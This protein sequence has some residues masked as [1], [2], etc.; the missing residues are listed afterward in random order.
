MEIGQICH[1]CATAKGWRPVTM[2]D[3]NTGEQIPRPVGMWEGK[4]DVCGE[5]KSLCAPRD[6]IDP[7]RPVFTSVLDI[8]KNS[9]Y[10]SDSKSPPGGE[11][12]EGSSMERLMRYEFSLRVSV[13]LA[14]DMDDPTP[15]DSA[16][17]REIL[18]ENA[19]DVIGM[20]SPEE[21]AADITEIRLIEDSSKPAATFVSV[22][23]DLGEVA[24]A[25]RYDPSRKFA[26]DIEMSDADPGGL[27]TDEFVRLE[28]GTEI[29]R[30]DGLKIEGYDD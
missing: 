6:Y 12:I 29:R 3:R 30:D 5:T 24:T 19:M 16:K 14:F 2:T 26:Y 9:R 27:H 22:W 25:C 17:L 1:E 28:D 21:F 20:M 10:M 8:L 13:P 7:E 4:C 11:K 15:D 23:S 18:A